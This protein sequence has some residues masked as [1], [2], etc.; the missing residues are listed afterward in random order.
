M[1]FSSIK[2][3]SYTVRDHLRVCYIS[4]FL[5][6]HIFCNPNNTFNRS[7]IPVVFILFYFILFFFWCEPITYSHMNLLINLLRSIPIIAI[8]RREEELPNYNVVQMRFFWNRI[9][10]QKGSVKFK[11]RDNQ[12]DK[13]KL[14][15][16]LSNYFGF[17]CHYWLT[18]LMMKPVFLFFFFVFEMWMTHTTTQ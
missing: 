18:Y 13:R 6:W 12:R 2:R 15:N 9:E 4:T 10:E 11:G 17:N 16:Q 8:L 5:S 14:Y 7:S 1:I 3:G